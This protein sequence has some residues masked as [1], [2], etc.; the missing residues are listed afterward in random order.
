MHRW[1]FV[2]LAG[3]AL[4]PGASFAAKAPTTNTV[5]LQASGSFKLL[6]GVALNAAAA[7][8]TIEVT[9]GRNFAKLV[10]FTDFNRSAATTVTIEPYCSPDGT[11]Y[12]RLQ[13]RAVASG[14]GTLSDYTDSNAVSGNEDFYTEYDARSCEKMKFI[15]AGASADGSDLVTVYGT[16]VVGD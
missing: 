6:D 5:R 8:R 12:F 13:S 7:T 11:L 1:I 10:L 16:G 3:L 14:T 4:A 9:T 15:Y 2:L